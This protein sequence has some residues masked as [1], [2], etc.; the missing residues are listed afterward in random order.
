MFVKGG[1]GGGNAMNWTNLPLMFNPFMEG[2]EG[3]GEGGG[4][5]GGMNRAKF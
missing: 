2:Q 1:G 5:G 3:E 4:G